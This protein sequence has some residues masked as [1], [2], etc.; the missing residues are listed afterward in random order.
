ML[1]L[2]EQ[3]ISVLRQKDWKT[4]SLEDKQIIFGVLAMVGGW[5]APLL[6]GSQVMA[7]INNKQCEATIIDGGQGKQKACLLLNDD[8]T[9]QVQR[10]PTSQIEG[11]VK[12][13]WPTEIKVDERSLCEALIAVYGRQQT[14]GSQ[15]CLLSEQFLLH[16]LLRVSSQMSW[17][18]V[19]R[20][21]DIFKQFMSI[22]TQITSQEG[23]QETKTMQY[24]AKAF[25]SSWE[26]IVDRE[27][28]KNRDFFIP[29]W[30]SDQAKKSKTKE[31]AKKGGEEA[32]TS[33][34]EKQDEALIT[35]YVQPVSSYLRGL[36]ELTPKK[37]QSMAAVKLLAYW[38]RNIIPKIIEFVRTTYR[39]WEMELSFEQLRYHLRQGNQANAMEEA[40]VMCEKKMPQGCTVPDDNHDWTAK[41]VEEC[42]VGSWAIA[43]LK[44]VRGHLTKQ[45]SRAETTSTLLNKLLK[46]G[47]DEIVVQ[48]KAADFRS[49]VILGEYHDPDSLLLQTV[50]LPVSI[51][52]DLHSPLPPSSVGY[53]IDLLHS[54]FQ[55]DVAKVDAL[56]AKQTLV[57]FFKSFQM[58]SADFAMPLQMPSSELKLETIISWSVW[59][60]FNSNPVMGWRKQLY[61]ATFIRQSDLSPSKQGPPSLI[62]LIE[63]NSQ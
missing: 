33:A 5:E 32:Q 44:F 2:L 18:S 19:G 9:L 12:Y 59:E 40:M 22:L 8:D 16:L 35:D 48:V 58:Q 27:E 57:Q 61:P 30:H 6:P 17:S 25:Y 43:K 46:L 51:L 41:M 62:S 52:Y 15:S 56:L 7:E 45:G 55:N 3:A 11:Q 63:Q 34:I 24:W 47:I 29:K 36:P 37:S 26:R 50:W 4:L 28:E 60:E 53:P 31:E 13:K 49:N 10:V 39:P 14:Q 20:D 23:T 38:E 21:Q 1:A 42:V 54:K